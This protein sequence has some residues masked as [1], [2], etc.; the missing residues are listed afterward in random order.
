MDLSRE[1]A[2][3]VAIHF[4]RLDS[5][6]PRASHD[7]V[8]ETVRALG[9][10]QLDTIS[11]VERTHHLVLHSRLGG[12][13]GRLLDDL[14][15][16]G[17]AVCDYW[18]NVAAIIP[19]E[20]RESYRYCW[21]AHRDGWRSVSRPFLD[22]VLRKSP[23]DRPFDVDDFGEEMQGRTRGTWSSSRLRSALDILVLEGFLIVHHREGFRKTFTHAANPPARL[24]ASSRSDGEVARFLLRRSLSAMGIGSLRE[25]M[26]A[27]LLPARVYR[28]EV[29]RMVREGVLDIARIRGVPDECYLLPERKPEIEKAV[30]TSATEAV[31]TLLSPFDNL[32][33]NRQRTLNLFGFRTRFEAYVPQAR[34]EY[35]YFMMPLLCGERLIGYADPKLDRKAGIMTF[36]SLNVPSKEVK[37][38]LPALVEEFVRFLRFHEARCLRIKGSGP[39]SFAREIESSVNRAV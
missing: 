39:G 2:A 36:H 18:T 7:A 38:S 35:G 21:T 33:I 8:L 29:H 11:A 16:E 13:R 26:V 20:D 1:E 19:A 31:A 5:P 23:Q 9:Y 17:R 14:L 30:A 12:Y 25:I 32:L 15:Y 6:R 34:R 24:R 4:Q 37:G 27:R 28:R 3:R 22:E 10:L